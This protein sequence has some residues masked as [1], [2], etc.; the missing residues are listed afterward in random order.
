MKNLLLIIMLLVCGKAFSQDSGWVFSLYTTPSYSFRTLKASGAG[1]NDTVQKL[2]AID[3]GVVKFDIGLRIAKNLGRRMRFTIGLAYT[4][5]GYESNVTIDTPSV[6]TTQYKTNV[7]QYN[8]YTFIEVP[9]YLTYKICDSVF[10]LGII[11][12]V[13]NSFLN[14]YSVD[15]PTYDYSTRNLIREPVVYSGA[16][17]TSNNIATYHLY[18][19]FGI[20]VGYQISD[21]FNLFAQPNVRY[22]LTN[23][24]PG[25]TQNWNNVDGRLYNIGASFGFDYKF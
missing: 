12:G 5:K 8:R 18:L 23:F 20:E 13:A 1:G 2:N 22:G 15:I 17:L 6:G 11:G 24:W 14:Q 4:S 7:I 25:G 9:V 16:D 10:K 19:L 3:K 21:H